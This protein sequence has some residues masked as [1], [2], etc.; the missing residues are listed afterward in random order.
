MMMEVVLPLHQLHP[1]QAG[2]DHQKV[3]HFLDKI[4]ILFFVCFLHVQDSKRHIFL[5]HISKKK[6]QIFLIF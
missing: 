6:F 4:F 1:P 3:L 5:V 2:P